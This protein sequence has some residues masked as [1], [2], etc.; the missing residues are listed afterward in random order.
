MT[1][2]P[3]YTD[4]L[5][6]ALQCLDD[7]QLQMLAQTI[8]ERVKWPKSECFSRWYEREIG[9]PLAEAKQRGVTDLEIVEKAWKDSAANWFA[10]SCRQ[11]AEK[12][13][14][15]ACAQRLE[16]R[17]NAMKKPIECNL[18]MEQNLGYLQKLK[19]ECNECEHN[20]FTAVIEGGHLYARKC[21]FCNREV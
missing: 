19:E 15:K 14:W 5:I 8:I 11:S 6:S 10:E 13:Q 20:G 17:I 9:L 3:H 21:E 1:T 2:S 4:Y 16:A 7:R 18:T 12:E